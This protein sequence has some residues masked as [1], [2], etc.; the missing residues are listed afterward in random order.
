MRVEWVLVAW[1]AFMSPL[2]QAVILLANNVV[3]NLLSKS[4]CR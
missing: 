1:D 2:T 3:G 4:I